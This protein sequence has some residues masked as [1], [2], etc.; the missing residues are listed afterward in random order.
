MDRDID[1]LLRLEI[2]RISKSEDINIDTSRSFGELGFDSLGYAEFVTIVNER[3]GVPLKV[4]TLF[5]HGSI[6]E[7]ISYVTRQVPGNT[8]TAPPEM[9]SH[10]S[11]R[12]SDTFD[13]GDVAIVGASARLPGVREFGSLWELVAQGESRLSGF[14][15][16][17]TAASDQD[18][19]APS[20]LCG[21]FIDD[22]DA[23]DASFFGISPREAIAMD[24]QQRISLEAAWH[25]FED[26][27]CTMCS[28]SGS[29]TAV[30]VGASSFDYYELLTASQNVRTTHIGTGVSHAIIANRIS[31]CFNLKGAS[32]C[33]DAACAS[34][35][36]AL[37]R[38]VNAIRR[39]ESRL[40]LVGGVNVLASRTPFRIFA[41]AGMLSKEGVC[42]PFDDD[43]GGYVRGEGVAF[44]V[45]KQARAAVQDRDRILA[46]IK[47]GA[48]KHS[49]HT[50]SLTAP[51]PDAQADVIVAAW[52]D[53]KVDPASIAYIE[54][55]GTGTTLGDPI[56]VEGL[57]KAFARMEERWNRST[58]TPHAF[59]GSIK[60]QIGHLEAAAGVAGVLKAVSALAHRTIPGSPYL[61]RL[62]R[63]IELHK[64][65]LRI[66]HSTVPWDG[67]HAGVNLAQVPR[68]A[69]VSSFGFGGTNAHVVLEEA[70][71]APSRSQAHA[72]PRLFLFSAKSA[73]TLR[74]LCAQFAEF[75]SCQRLSGLGVE[76]MYLEDVAFTLRHRRSTLNFRLAVIAS[77]LEEL[78][79]KLRVAGQDH[80]HGPG[81]YTGISS[82]SLQKNVGP[83]EE[84]A[85][86]LARHDGSM[87]QLDLDALAKAW[88][89]GSHIDW[90]HVLPRGSAMPVSLPHYP[91]ARERFWVNDSRVHEQ[92]E[93]PSPAGGRAQMAAALYQAQWIPVPLDALPAASVKSELLVLVS[94][95]RGTQ[96]AEAIRRMAP[97][98]PM[99][100]IWC[101]PL[102]EPS[103]EGDTNGASAQQVGAV[104]DLTPLDDEA[105]LRLDIPK[106]LELVRQLIGKTLKRGEPIKIVHA[107]FGILNMFENDIVP[108]TLAGAQDAGLYE[109]LGAEY[110]RCQSKTVNLSQGGA[111]AGMVAE[112]LVCELLNH[113]GNCAV[114][115]V[116]GHRYARKIRRVE[117]PLSTVSGPTIETA[118]I[119]GGTG[120]IGLALARDLVERGCRA[121]LLTGRTMLSPAKSA[122]IQEL[123][124]RGA[125]ISIYN[126]ELT[127]CIT[128]RAAIDRFRASHGPI[129]HVFHCAGTV[130]TITLAFFRKTAASIARV[131]TPKVAALQVLHDLFLHDPPRAFVLFSSMASIIPKAAVGVLDYS[132]ANR[133][134]DVFARYQRG[135]GR[136][137]YRSILWPQWEGTGLAKHVATDAGSGRALPAELCLKVLHAV[138][139]SG[140]TLP[141]DVGV[142]AEGDTILE[143]LSVS[144]G[145]PALTRTD[146]FPPFDRSMRSESLRRGLC[147]LVA[148]EL[149]TSESK[150]DIEASFEALGIDSIVLTG[151]IVSIETWL[152]I[153]VDPQEI[154][155][156]NSI[157]AV[158]TY[159]EGKVSPTA[160]ANIPTI[161]P[162]LKGNPNGENTDLDT[163][164]RKKVAVIGMA[165]RFPGAPDKETF[166]RNLRDG[167]ESVG[168]VPASRWNTAGR[169]AP[170]Y[171]AGC[172][173]SRW[174]GFIGDL[175]WVNPKLYGMN[176]EEAKDIDPLVRLF[177]ECSLEAAGDSVQGVD[178]LQGKRVGVFVGARASGYAERI[179]RP[180]KHSVTGI[181]QNFI[182][183]H[184]SHALDLRGPSLIVDSACSSSLAAIHLA[185]QSLFSG[186][187]DLALAGGVEVL[188]DEKP[189]LFLSA[190]HALSTDGR[191]RPF[192][193]KANGFV[194]GEGVGCVLLK[195]LARALDDGDPIYAV[196]EGSAMNNDGHTLG[197]TTPGVSG[198]VDVIRRALSNAGLAPCDISYVEAHGTGT[199]IGDPI[200][201]QALTQAFQA[202]P[203]KHCALGS[204]KSNI[205]H[206][207]SAAGVASFIKVALALH[208]GTLPP[209]L[210]CDEVNP[211]L[212]IERT[213]FALLQRAT[214]WESEDEPRHGGISAFGFGKTNV[215]MVLGERPITAR[216]PTD[217][218]PP[219]ADGRMGK[220]HA[221]HD[222]RLQRDSASD[223]EIDMMLGIK[224]E[225]FEEL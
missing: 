142:M 1:Q 111:D 163:C 139:N 23:F 130:D 143:A 209:S 176:A 33:I 205:G 48:V 66:P 45:L 51:N 5:E 172:S 145:S 122:V 146:E 128:L 3:F 69:G 110:K 31:Q 56:E 30:F 137:Y 94:G 32:E 53:A 60:A 70:P 186:D 57:R 22:V 35:L 119:T 67:E 59:I 11:T 40:A 123:E 168:V 101:P 140:D 190:A 19:T 71:L 169:Y 131:M 164:E 138:L 160:V 150:L 182:A 207:L 50:Q 121:L 97:E 135:Q 187:S 155:R 16:G 74:L 99:K 179:E 38:G 21:G 27:G 195:P 152:G 133:F 167:V 217:R 10:A 88:V 91:F 223:D 197:I 154:I 7:T 149:E 175:E 116:D 126:G 79:A 221:W 157:A 118:F 161:D 73:E 213:P 75:L 188:L 219:P 54:A 208:H 102:D 144:T 148:K 37:L 17:R 28:L 210:H 8:K 156:R 41:D 170:R 114:A 86:E 113:D 12:G 72:H 141:A 46:I 173:V 25:A 84:H 108:G 218:T 158:A 199:L 112:Q 65:P 107:T 82:S 90:T 100:T 183:A 202:R 105:Y 15:R 63:Y 194:P 55:H 216:R 89:C 153:V 115:Y 64:S 147:T 92:A 98:S 180:G 201:L 104:L 96:V 127:N 196:I 62:N 95:L 151:L 181:G 76:Q 87:E 29:D 58:M 165:C 52:E 192:D 24:P 206:L 177:T 47:G 78:T 203:P 159:L 14:P 211:R 81:V 13:T 6:D 198:Q 134:L 77:S 18:E 191:C 120:D 49:G 184:I 44:V 83:S 2:A 117:Y 39:N 132:A 80:P 34:S 36:V 85:S 93:V 9:R 178:G 174:G 200:E 103:S 222:A 220:I 171:K 193:A 129:T 20:F 212:D 42:R 106:K 26:A 125:R 189:Y 225:V 43:A 185:C 109:H 215:H 68:R 162:P 136:T 61:N 124:Q 214:H 224:V 166:W 4:E 204:V